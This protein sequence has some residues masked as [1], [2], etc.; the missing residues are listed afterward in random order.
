MRQQP[1]RFR[2][3]SAQLTSNQRSLMKKSDFWLAVFIAALVA[4][5]EEALRNQKK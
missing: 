4:A 2:P 1:A 3:S 5:A